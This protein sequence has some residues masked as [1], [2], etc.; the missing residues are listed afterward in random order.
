MICVIVISE[1]QNNLAAEMVHT[2]SPKGGFEDSSKYSKTPYDH[3]NV[4][5]Y[6]T[7]LF[8]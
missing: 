8:E 5:Y 3:N 1:S 6:P 4:N 2:L 7:Q